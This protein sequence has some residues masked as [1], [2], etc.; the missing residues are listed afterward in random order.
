MR[1]DNTDPKQLNSN[2]TL[3]DP[4]KDSFYG[5]LEM[6]KYYPLA[7]PIYELM[8]QSSNSG[9]PIDTLYLYL[10]LG[11]P[12]KMM[13]K[14]NQKRKNITNMY[15]IYD[16]QFDYITNELRNYPDAKDALAW[17]NR[18]VE[19]RE[20]VEKHAQRSFN[21]ILK[22]HIRQTLPRAEINYSSITFKP[23]DNTT[24]DF[25]FDKSLR[26][27]DTLEA[28]ITGI[29]HKIE[30]AEYKPLDIEEVK[31]YQ[32]TINDCI[33]KSKQ[34]LNDQN[35]KCPMMARY[36]ILKTEAEKLIEQRY[37]PV[38]DVYIVANMII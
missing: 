6:E 4:I 31:Q 12:C 19:L 21:D 9:K 34:V 26:D 14:G 23:N 35:N 28:D 16:T 3:N 37:K 8:L 38:L 33:E 22:V 36:N 17:T 15:G 7:I 24:I 13:L 27:D 2:Q 1:H 10:K 18:L 30:S 20:D 5:A 25:K 32:T 29:E 11:K